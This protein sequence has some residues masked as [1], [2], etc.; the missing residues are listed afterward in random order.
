DREDMQSVL[1]ENAE[2]GPSPPGSRERM[3]EELAEGLSDLLP[4]KSLYQTTL[5]SS[6]QVPSD[7]R[8]ALE[9]DPD[10]LSEQE[11][12]EHNRRLLEAAFP[13]YIERSPGS[14]YYVR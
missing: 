8:K 3:Q 12:S 14:A 10:T 9:S 4:S 5:W 6:T 11:L 2:G 1:E 13:T 7:T